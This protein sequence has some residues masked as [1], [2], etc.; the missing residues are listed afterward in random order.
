[1]DHCSVDSRVDQYCRF[2][3]G[4]LFHL[5]ILIVRER[6]ILREIKSD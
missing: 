6:F 5:E 2:V 4:S 1:M 3:I